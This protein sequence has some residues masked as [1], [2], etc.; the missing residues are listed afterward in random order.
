MI[1]EILFRLVRAPDVFVR[2]VQRVACIQTDGE[3][4]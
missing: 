1:I 2:I 4:A 3:Q